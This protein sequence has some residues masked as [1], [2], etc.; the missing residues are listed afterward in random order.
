MADPLSFVATVSNIVKLFSIIEANLEAAVE[1]RSVRKSLHDAKTPSQHT[2][3]PPF[4][5]FVDSFTPF[6]T[7]NR[8]RR[9]GGTSQVSQVTIHP[10]HILGYSK[11]TDTHLN[12][13]QK[14]MCALKQ[15]HAGNDDDFFR[16]AMNLQRLAQTPHPHIVPLLASYREKSQYHL[17][18]PWAECDLAMFWRLHPKPPHDK[19]TLEWIGRQMMGLADALSIIHGSTENNEM[20]SF[21]GVHGDLKPA[22]ILWFRDAPERHT[23][24]ITDFGS[25]Y[26]LPSDEKEIAKPQ[27]IKRTPAYRAPEVDITS[28]GVT[29]A[30]DIWGFGCI[31]SQALLWTLDGLK[32]LERLSEARHDEEHNSPNRDAFFQ[33]QRTL[34]GVRSARLKPQVQNLLWSMRS[35]PHSTPF[36]NDILDLVVTGMLRIDLHQRM[37][38]HEVARALAKICKRLDEDAAYSEFHV[39]RKDNKMEMDPFFQN[40]YSSARSISLT[41]SVLQVHTNQNASQRP[42][43]DRS[44]DAN[45]YTNTTTQ[46]FDGYIDQGQLKPRFACPFFK[47]G[48]RIS[49][50]H[51]ACEG[52]G[53]TDINKVKEHIF[54]THLVDHHKTKYV[55]RRCDEGFKTDELFLAHQHQELACHKI[56]SQPAYGKLTREQTSSLRSLKRKYTKISDEERWF[57]I[58]KLVNPSSDPRCDGISPYCESTSVSMRTLNSTSSSGISQYKDYLLQRNAEGYMAELASRGIAVPLEI[59]TKIFEMQVKEIENFDEARRKPVLAYEITQASC[60]KVGIAKGQDTQVPGENSPISQLLASWDNNEAEG[61]LQC[62]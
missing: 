55:C 54:R 59:A 58:Y 4:F 47:A 15:F 30:Y 43:L 13:P 48:I 27:N 12:K 24:A 42:R 3:N 45:Y 28:E 19:R 18:F 16:E 40:S 61:D 21:Y 25:S 14:H 35:H 1:I 60:E 41:R 2:T 8:I 6:V 44:V 36:S 32:G 9:C 37:T 34:D 50:R 31:L 49:A 46:S 56:T 33:L 17:V 29:Q 22:N 5:D 10:S 39:D 53:W 52:P 51:R 20:S 23:L 57:E 26:F 11:S 62:R 7:K 38:S